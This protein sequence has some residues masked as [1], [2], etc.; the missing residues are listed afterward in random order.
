MKLNFPRYPAVV[1][2]TNNGKRLEKMSMPFLANMH[3][4]TTRKS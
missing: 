1:G 3:T 2:D 4:E